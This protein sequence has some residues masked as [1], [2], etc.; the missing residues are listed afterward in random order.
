M[1]MRR[2]QPISAP[3]Q[4][5]VRGVAKLAHILRAGAAERDQAGSFAAGSL[6]ALVDEGVLAACVPTSLGGSGVESLHD[7]ACVTAC[8]AE[9]DPSVAIGLSMHLGLSWYYART[10]RCAPGAPTAAKHAGWLSAI[11]NREMIVSSAV[12]EPGTVPW[13]HATQAILRGDEWIINGFKTLVSLSPAATHFYTRLTA[14]TEAGRRQATVMLSRDIPGVTV[15]N[16][17]NGL[18]LRASGSGRVLFHDVVVPKSALILRAPWGQRDEVDA[19]G[20]AANA[21]PILGV[22]LGIAQAM[23]DISF[24]SLSSEARLKTAVR[25]AIVDVELQLA[26]ARSTFASAMDMLDRVL[27]V[28]APKTVER[29]LAT[30][31]FV[32]VVGA[33]MLIEQAV[34]RVADLTMQLGGGKSY[35]AGS[36][37]ARFYRDARGASFMRPYV[38]LDGWMDFLADHTL[39]SL[40]PVQAEG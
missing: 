12:A 15:E 3:G 25:A 14:H 2:L 26:T 38:P 40:L 9:S 23:R 18:G 6:R 28:Q 19:E 4:N 32:N 33:A 29:L 21:P 35:A 34:L 16:D 27:P 22:Y 31:L 36:T 8:V 37:L 17:W 11:G 10:V 30:E 20:R 24:A 5:V 1:L 13:K 7:V 39:A